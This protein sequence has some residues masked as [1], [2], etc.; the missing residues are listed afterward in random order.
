MMH[1]DD[2]LDRA[3]AALPLEEPPAAF[4]ARVLAAT[5]YAPRVP[6]PTRSLEPWLFGSVA[7]LLVWLSWIV[8]GDGDAGRRITGT[9]ASLLDG[10]PQISTEIWLWLAIGA[11]T[12]LWL[13]LLTVPAPRR[14]ATRR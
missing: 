3:L 1:D 9:I 11:A 14:V 10:V 13:S 4:R 12:A 7:A 6:A 2:D 5:V 8:L